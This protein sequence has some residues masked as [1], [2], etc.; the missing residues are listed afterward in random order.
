[1]VARPYDLIVATLCVFWVAI[2]TFNE[3]GTFN[4]R[5][6][7]C[8]W[9]D[10]ALESPMDLTTL[11]K[12]QP[13]HI[14]VLADPQILDARSYPG[15]NP[16]LMWLSQM[17]VDL[18]L[19]KSWRAVQKLQP[20]AVVFLGDMMD[21]GRSAVSDEEYEEYFQRFQ[22][23]FR[24]S[25]SGSVP[26]YY[27]PG[28]HDVGLGASPR[29][30]D[31]AVARYTSHFGSLNQ[32]ID[33]GEYAFVLIDA[34]GLVEEETQRSRS[35][36]A[37]ANWASQYR[38]GGIAFIDSFA[39][40]E[41][42]KPT[43]LFTHIPLSRPDGASC[44]ALR[45]QGAIR[46][47]SGHGYQNTLSPPT[48]QFL[49][50]RTRPLLVLSGDDHD[51]CEYS[52]TYEAYTDDERAL[53]FSVK[54][55]TVKSFSMAMGIREPGFQL[56]S[57]SSSS[58]FSS[59][60]LATIPCLLPD[61]LGTYLRI[62]VPSVILSLLILFI[63]NA[64]RVR[65][66]GRWVESAPLPNWCQGMHFSRTFTLRGRRIRLHFPLQEGSLSGE[67]EKI[68]SKPTRGS[69]R[70]NE[71]LLLGWG[72]DVVTVA[73]VPLLWFVGIAWWVA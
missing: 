41:H 35:G 70:G 46:K 16:W 37:Y 60:T 42:V 13:L 26:R 9:P 49:L 4:N 29:F 71:G 14:L 62:Y 51:Y 48:S 39:S 56:L 72:R 55:V 57:L 11:G 23:I 52:H 15:R 30:S 6:A 63:S 44:G 36:L 47:G 58:S 65:T 22:R 31:R 27:L 17:I 34:P 1:V 21:G 69:G 2:V 59:E 73:C 3:I 12:A 25:S 43:V 64:H 18:Y 19:R 67:E 20:D 68:T 28:N 8:K 38:D 54:E 40:R 61:Q 50:Q 24:S 10:T 7:R 33:V 53:S 5:I 66:R 45:E 32:V